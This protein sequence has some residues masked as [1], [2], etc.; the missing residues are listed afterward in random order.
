MNY[1]CITTIPGKMKTTANASSSQGASG[2]ERASISFQTVYEVCALERDDVGEK[3]RI[4]AINRNTW[5]HFSHI[6][7][8]NILI[9]I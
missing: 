7:G 2:I 4:R 9:S 6:L 5:V 3:A 1:V 8:R